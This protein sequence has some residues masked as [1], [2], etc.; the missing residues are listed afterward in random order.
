MVLA[1]TTPPTLAGTVGRPRL[2]RRLDRARRR[3]VTWVSAPPGAGKTT[4]VAS[5]L[6]VRRQRGLWYQVDEGDGDLATFF[7]YLGLAAPRRRRRLPLLTPEY[8]HDV[9][10]FTRR[11][12][13]ELF[14]RLRSPFTVVFDNYQEVP[15]RSVLHDVMREA[16]KE[17]PDGGRVIF[18]SR[19]EPP[20]AF[21]R[22]LTHQMVET[23]GWPEL[24]F[25]STE[26]KGLVRKLAR[27]RWSGAAMRSIYDATEGWC[28]GL[29]LLLDQV[30]S[31]GCAMPGPRQPSLEVLFDYFAGEI[32]AKAGPEVQDVLLQTA[33]LP[34]VT[35]P[36]A[37][38]LTGLPAAGDTLVTLHK[39][40]YF[41]TK[42]AG[43]PPTYVYHPLF[44]EFLLSRAARAYS[45][46]R[47]AKIRRTAASLIET[48]GRVEAAA[49]LLRDAEDWAGLAQMVHRHGATLLSQGRGETIEE[50][51]GNLPPAIF[52]EQPWLLFWRGMGWLAWR[53]AKCQ[54]ALEQ[55]FMAFRRQGDTIGMFLAWAGTI[56]AYASEGEAVPFD[57][58]IA[59]FDEIRKKAPELPTKGVETR[60]AASMLV[61]LSFRQPGHPQA[62]HWAERAI[63][64]ARNHPD[65]V[66]RAMTAANWLL[67]Q[68]QVGD[69]S[70]VDVV[71]DEMRTLM[72]TRGVSPV[73]A[74][75][76]C[77]TV[78]WYE[79]A[80]ALPSYRR[81]VAET[82]ELARTTGM[83][84]T[85]RHVV[86]CG[87]LMAA[88]SDG[89]LETAAPWL[90]EL[91]RDVHLLGPGFRYWHHWLVVWEALL[92]GEV[93][94][95]VGYQPEMLRLARAGGRPLD[96]AVAHL[97]SAQALQASGDKGGPRTHV[98]RALKIALAIRSPYLEF[99]VRLT[100][101]QL[102]LDVGQEREALRALA[103]AMALGRER[104][105]VTSH[106]WIPGVVASLC[107]RALD[108]NIEVGYVRALVQKRGLILESPPADL[109]AW[110]WP[111]KVFTLGHFEV[112]R[113][114]EPIRFSRKVQ[115]KPLALL[116]T[117]IALGGRG[118]R[119]DLVMDALWADADGDAA[120]RALASALH[121]LRR[122]LGQEG[123]VIR[124][125]GHL[126]LNARLC[127]VDAWAVER[128]LARGEAAI[129]RE[130][131]VRKAADLYRGAFL[132]GDSGELPHATGL[133]DSLWR[134]LLLSMARLGRQYERT[135]GQRAADWYEEGLRVDPCAEDV[136]RSVMAVYHRLGR[137]AA[138]LSAYGRCRS[139]LAS[140][141]G[142]APSP[143][144]ER[145]LQT[146]RQG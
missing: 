23:L 7:Y 96:E 22:F 121:R 97:M 135:D 19:S 82:L 14:G 126:S 60:V 21:A 88:L 124:Q 25:T 71:A 15:S 134:R 62:A 131:D 108:A 110:P 75:N 5:Y 143:E 6:A 13:R 39:Q 12:F 41:T 61:A 100:E 98:E 128:L 117:L 11:F 31:E 144:T 90:R 111:I 72:T 57:R 46:E 83:F 130:E 139:A 73:V 20:P 32:F 85:A 93:A 42:R 133:A 28:A 136:C 95:A 103:T 27:G 107:A 30:S 43:S 18:I 54:Q 59:L 69:F 91:E 119:E 137:R 109:E 120:R 138:A 36:M 58:W 86:L 145:L 74:V 92:R 78:A 53:H 76:A 102:C 101:A 118:V 1:K 16:L 8:R 49:G 65:P 63:G 87:G 67:Y 35:G 2:F 79:A 17:I 127:W 80:K 123:A 105:Y 64:L 122:L 132:D 81:T 56:Y 116:K 33:F 24:A 4:L 113:Q 140:R 89:D 10:V 104:G 50:W 84:Y 38:A 34:E 37:Q 47:R 51:L 77:M 40:N 45:P 125:E 94:R 26:A 68:W 115:R 48:A 29:I 44:R 112:L 106:V 66:L 141:L 52:D 9:T 55:A 3:P 70:G 114:D 99:M 146:V 142:A 129:G